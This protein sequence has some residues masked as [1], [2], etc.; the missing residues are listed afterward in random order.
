MTYC[1]LVN[2]KHPYPKDA[3]E[4]LVYRPVRKSSV[5]MERRAAEALTAL[6]ETVDREGQ[7]VPVSG[8]RSR[9]EQREIWEQCLARRG[10]AYTRKYVA[11]EGCSEHETGLAIDLGWMG[12]E[13]GPLDEIAPHFPY[14]GICQDFRS[15][16]P[17]YGF[18]QRYPKGGEKITGIGHEPWHFRYV[19]TP[20]GKI[21][22]DLGLV[23]E[24]YVSLKEESGAS[25]GKENGDYYADFGG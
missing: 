1:I 21:I 14:S 8:Y 20:H 11:P 16:A 24:E 19:G 4:A 9:E 6:L 13:E 12:E 3:G 22:T 18:I 5:F 7:I 2:E 15:L 25:I 23:L 17:E 10:L